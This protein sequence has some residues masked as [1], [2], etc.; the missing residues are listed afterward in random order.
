MKVRQE[1]MTNILEK[2]SLH[3]PL[4]TTMLTC[5]VVYHQVYRLDVPPHHLRL[6]CDAELQLDSSSVLIYGR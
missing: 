4:S 2:Y 3:Q 6:H 1:R 5:P